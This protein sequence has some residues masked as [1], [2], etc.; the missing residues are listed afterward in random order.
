M[1]HRVTSRD[2]RPTY[3]RRIFQGNGIFCVLGGVIL[4]VGSIPIAA[5]FRWQAPIALSIAGVMLAAYGVRVF[6]TALRVPLDLTAAWIYTLLDACW[7]AG[8]A[9]V[10][11]AGRRPLTVAATCTIALVAL[12]VACFAAMQLVALLRLRPLEQA[13]G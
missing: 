2:A 12:V 7:V 3:V 4:L 1:L 9:V 6:V 5:V 10:L 13:N 11:V 8:S